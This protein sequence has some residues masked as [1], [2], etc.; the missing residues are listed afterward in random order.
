MAQQQ[1]I[2]RFFGGG[3]NKPAKASS[4]SI[5]TMLASPKKRATGQTASQE[6]KRV[7]TEAKDEGEAVKEDV[8]VTENDVKQNDVKETKNDTNDA[9]SATNSTNSAT[10][11]T[12]SMPYARVTAVFESIEHESSRL[13]ITALVADFF[14]HILNT[15]TP[16]NLTKIVYLFI[17]RLGPDYEPDLELGLGE[18]LLIKAIS[19]CYGRPPAK[20]KKDYQKVGD[21]GLVAQNSRSG[22]PTMFKPVALDVDTVFDNLTKIAKSTG[23]DSQAKKIALIKKMLTACD[24]KSNE[25][26]FLIRSLEGKLRIGLAEKTVLIGLAQAFVAY[27]GS[28]KVGKTIKT[29]NTATAEEVVREAFSQVPNYEIIIKHAYAH[30]IFNL[31]DHCQLTPGIPLKPMLAKPTKSIS[32]VLDRFQG[33]EFT[34]EYKYDGERAQV[35]MLSD[36]LV[37]IYSRNSEDMSQRYPDLISIAKDFLKKQEGADNNVSSMILDCEAVA[38]D[39]VNKKILPFQ[40]LSTRKRKG[41]DEKDITVHI[42]LFAFDLLYLDNV[43]LITKSLKERRQVM[44]EN[45]IPIEG[46]FQFATAKNSSNLDE[47]QQFL[48]QSVKDACEGLMVKML[49]GNESYYEPSKR[50]RNWLKLK[51]DYLAGVGDSLD[52]VV[53]GAY[54]GKGKRTGSYGGFLL[55]SYNSDTG[56]YETTCKIGTGFSDED[57]VQIHAKLHPTEISQPKPYFVYDT[58]NSNAKPD[59]W[60]EPS[61]IF[62][63]LTAD[64]SLSPIYKAGHQQYGKGI[65]LRFPRFLRIRDDK[66]IEDGTNSEQVAEFYERQANIN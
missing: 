52:L 40:V 61:M 56:E 45:L 29:A 24:L 11:T 41:V 4:P 60:F 54:I 46:K 5:T 53:I 51:K 12:S 59:V 19:E 15:S 50:S 7:K 23:K 34:C 14:L 28:S 55:A 44:T 42:C 62:E 25:A 65:S 30:G 6:P 36:G 9:T 57:L 1:S 39:R 2:A 58:T 33:E 32:E 47:L 16:E 21:L 20:I 35:H 10:S 27:E 43:S 17:N 64:L 18:T 13:K 31:L 63:V 49:N 38:W 37:R 26:K 8:E 48:D 22:Q 66:G 3:A